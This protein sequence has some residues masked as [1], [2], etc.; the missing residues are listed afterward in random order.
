MTL[1]V[2]IIADD[3]TGA[4]D[5]GTPFVEA[6]LTVAVAIDVEALAEALAGSPDVLVVNTASRALSADEAA[7]RI[8]AVAAAIGAETSLILFK[9]IE[10]PT[11]GQRRRRK[12]RARQCNG[13]RNDHSCARHSRS[14]ALHGKRRGHGPRRGNAVTNSADISVQF[15]YGRHL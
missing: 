15:L 13:P 3:L 6:G 14:A 2:V 5:T 10:F 9:K 11:E 7:A 1:Q 12:H 8:D 4:L